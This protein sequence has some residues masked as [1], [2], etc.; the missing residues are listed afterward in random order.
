[1]ELFH[2]AALIIKTNFPRDGTFT[3]STDWYCAYV[4]YG[5]IRYLSGLIYLKT[6]P[7][8]RQNTVSRVLSIRYGFVR[9]HLQGR[10]RCRSGAR[11][12]YPNAS[13]TPRISLSCVLM[14]VALFY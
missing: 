7:F 3:Y 12:Q 5:T 9:E 1:M 6:K 13:S 10:Q 2:S 14:V 11:N 8:S 4:S